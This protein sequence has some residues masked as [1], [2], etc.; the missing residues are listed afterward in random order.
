MN[1]ANTTTPALLNGLDPLAVQAL[2]DSIT[3]DPANG[4][5]HWNVVSKWQGGARARATVKR[6]TVGGEAIDRP[7]VIDSDEPEQLG[8]INKAPN[9]Q[10]L[11]LAALNACMTVGYAA[12]ATLMGIEIQ[13]LEIETKGDIDLRGFLGISPDVKPG[14]ESL[15]Y[16]V[17]IKSS[18]TDEQIQQIH[19]LVQKT[20][21]N[22]FNISRPVRLEAKLVCV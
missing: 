7:W 21:P 14:Y 17:R 3:A 11:L 1:A 22:Y 18:G 6:V 16:T 9:P 19:E 2:I 15:Q 8:G 10:E 4:Q 20:S 12:L 5:T 13:S